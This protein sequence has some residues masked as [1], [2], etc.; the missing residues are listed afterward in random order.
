[1]CS[2]VIA[3]YH[4]GRG[5]ECQGNTAFSLG[6]ISEVTPT[7]NELTYVMVSPTLQPE[8]A[9][10]SESVVYSRSLKRRAGDRRGTR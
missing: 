3:N 7:L 10:Q 8:A 5:S 9:V 6:S 2:C 1:M 4:C